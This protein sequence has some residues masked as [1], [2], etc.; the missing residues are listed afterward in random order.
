VTAVSLVVTVRNEAASIRELL[1]SIDAQTRAPDEV[2]I[3]DGGSTDGTQKLLDE[4]TNPSR[5]VLSEPGANIARGRN[6][7]IARAA[8]DVVAVTDAGCVL[9][10]DWLERLAGA[11]DGADVAMGFYEPI[12]ATFFERVTTCLTLPDAGQIDPSAFM[13]SSRSVAF[14]KD[15]WTRAGGYPEWLDIGEDMY[16]NFAVLRTGAR[17][18]FV[19]DAIARWHTRPTLG[20]F[21]R[22]YFRYARGD[23]IAGMYPRRHA[24]RFGSYAA[25]ALL[26]ALAV[27]RWPLLAAIP[28]FGMTAWLRPAF[29]R[30]W[31]RMSGAGRV[32]AFVLMPFL[33]VAQDIAKMAGYAAGLPHRRKR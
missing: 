1:S 29:G 20:A 9:E 8:G 23:A 32:G 14:T 28:A 12:A 16:F 11:L 10:K 13:P 18:V 2:V 26:V 21:L 5:V 7:A 30:A 27:T 24:V 17:R 25:S 6:T 22:Q 15:L 31:R 3:V 33:L 19:P 4:W